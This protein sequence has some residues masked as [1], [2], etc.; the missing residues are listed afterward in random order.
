MGTPEGRGVGLQLRFLVPVHWNC[1]K[2][3][4]E[5]DCNA[6]RVSMRLGFKRKGLNKNEV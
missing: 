3:F 6:T 5:G 1:A 4:Y 2:G